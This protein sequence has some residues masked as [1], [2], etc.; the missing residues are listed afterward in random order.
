MSRPSSTSTDSANQFPKPAGAT[1]LV[2]DAAGDQLSPSR[3]TFSFDDSPKGSD[4][5]FRP[6]S[7]NETKAVDAAGL[8]QQ[9]YSTRRRTQYYEDQFAYKDDSTSS[10]RDRVTKDAPVVAELKTNVIVRLSPMFHSISYPT[11]LF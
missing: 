11:G 1:L 3:S 6:A 7:R 9:N 5:I 8:R 4:R 2:P 10:A